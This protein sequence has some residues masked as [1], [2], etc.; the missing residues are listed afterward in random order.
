MDRAR[1]LTDKKLKD[2]EKQISRVYKMHPALLQAKQEYKEY[3]EYVKKQTQK[4]YDDYVKEKD[5]K[6]KEVLKKVYTDKV[7][8]LTLQSAKYKRIENRLLNA[9]S[10]ANQSALDI[11]NKAIP[12]I[13][14]I[15]YNQ[16]AVDCK[17]VGIKVV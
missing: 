9:M 14:T 13:Y 7:K 3:L 8:K 6:K 11:I 17:Q 4:E 15:N 16:V 2:V 10:Q 1:Q 12:E 5:E